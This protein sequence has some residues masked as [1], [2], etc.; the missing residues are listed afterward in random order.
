MR[1]VKSLN[2]HPEYYD[3]LLISLEESFKYSKENQ[4]KIDFYPLM[5]KENWS[6][7]FI[8]LEDGKFAGHIGVL[9]KKML[10]Q[11]VALLGGIFISSEFQGKGLFSDFILNVIDNFQDA[12]LFILHSDLSELYKKFGF[13]LC[14]GQLQTG[15]DDINIKAPHD[16]LKTKLNKLS[17]FEIDQL[18]NIY[19]QSIAKNFLTL[20]RSRADWELLKNITSSDLFIKKDSDVI[21]SYFFANKGFDLPSIIH[22]IGHI[23]G[24]ILHILKDIHQYKVWVP[25]HYTEFSNSQD[26]MYLGL[27]KIG[28]INSLNHI[29]K[30]LTHNE[31]EI[32][33]IS[34]SKITIRHLDENHELPIETLLGGLFG[35]NRYED[36]KK[37]PPLYI[38]GLD[39]V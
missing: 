6:N 22:E 8:L 33:D 39:S 7:C 29:L 34:F 13:Y 28:N 12:A 18:A 27:I 37:Y 11:T 21:K 32:L 23:S 10:G 4:F 3:H 9:E 19:D 20:E 24:D 31:I 26:L 36:L 15:T 5:R 35:P 25:E 16:F 14:G 17:S 38:S 1:E 2:Q 30:Q